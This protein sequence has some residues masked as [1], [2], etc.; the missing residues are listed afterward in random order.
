M[1][2]KVDGIPVSIVGDKKG[3][4][5]DSKGGKWTRAANYDCDNKAAYI[6]DIPESGAMLLSVNE[7]KRVCKGYSAISALT[8][9]EEVRD[10]LDRNMPEQSKVLSDQALREVLIKSDDTGISVEKIL[11][12]SRIETVVDKPSDGVAPIPAAVI[13]GNTEKQIE[14]MSRIHGKKRRKKPVQP[15]G[16][17]C[18]GVVLTPRQ[19]EFLER[20]SE[21][22]EWGAEEENGW[23]FT[24][25]YSAELADTMK[26]TTVGA[27]LSTLKEK[28]VIITQYVRDSGMRRSKFKLTEAGVKMYRIMARKG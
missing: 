21:N 14:V 24:D 9:V 1:I 13:T 7:L 23:Y 22:P 17:E 4:L 12:S 16:F 10:F 3:V 27:M 19:V 15:D 2:V 6:S 26:V 11:R 28:G 18:D 8:T 20:L 25:D 5:L